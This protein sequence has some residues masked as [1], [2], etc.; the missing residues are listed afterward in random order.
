M[1]LVNVRSS[2]PLG[3]RPLLLAVL[4]AQVADAVSFAVG[5][6]RLGIG[7][8]ANPLMRAAYEVG[9]T[10]GVL[11]IKAGAIALM[12]AMLVVAGRHYPRL[13]ALGG[14]FAIGVGALGASMNTLVMLL[15]AVG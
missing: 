3:I 13:A 9:G 1:A 11:G 6:S 15:L 10:A 4:A 5:V 8:E 2:R 14:A 7:V 12:L